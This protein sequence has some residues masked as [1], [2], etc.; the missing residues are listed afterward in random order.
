L[1]VLAVAASGANCP[2][3]RAPVAEPVPAV[4]PP[5]PTMGQIIDVVNR[6]RL[7]VHSL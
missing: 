3:R 1:L 2:L 6:N 4:L 5:E 7:A